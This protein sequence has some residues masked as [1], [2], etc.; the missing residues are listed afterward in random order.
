MDPNVGERLARYADTRLAEDRDVILAHY[1]PLVDRVVRAMNF[2]SHVERDDLISSGVFGLID[3][4]E[5]FEPD[6]GIQFQTYASRRIK[7]AVI[8]E[9]RTSDWTTRYARAKVRRLAEA[10]DKLRDGLGRDATEGE[11][12]AELDV[13]LAGV[14]DLRSVQDRLQISSL[15]TSEF[16]ENTGPNRP[17]GS[18]E[19][20]SLGPE[21]GAGDGVDAIREE[22]VRS[23]TRLP[24][25][26]RLVLALY[27]FEH[28]TMTQIGV[29]MQ[30]ARARV[31]IIHTRAIA[32]LQETFARD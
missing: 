30:V 13:E 7:G 16:N 15:Q 6:R 24:E 17:G 22:L 3:A 14:H 23:I 2:P 32:R 31:C 21:I 29:E 10:E 5:R 26:D 20:P 8:G 1:Y 9:L 4:L 12:A 18:A 11:L 25:P 28:L 19:P 27:F